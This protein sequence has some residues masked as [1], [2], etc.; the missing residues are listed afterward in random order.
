[1]PTQADYD[2]C[3]AYGHAWDTDVEIPFTRRA[4]GSVVFTYRLSARC[5]RCTTI[6]HDALDASGDVASR[7]Y[8]YP[9]DYKYPTGDT[10]TRAEFRMRIL[11]RHQRRYGRESVR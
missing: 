5:T 3:R 4:G 8:V 9:E 7:Q 2:K 11:E 10:P 1:M 6:R